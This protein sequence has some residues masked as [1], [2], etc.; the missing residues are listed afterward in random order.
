MLAQ[1][2]VVEMRPTC[3]TIAIIGDNGKF[4][5]PATGGLQFYALTP[6]RVADTRTSQP[7]TGAFGPPSLTVYT[8]RNFPIQS[9]PVESRQPHRRMR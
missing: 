6:C 8:D 3:L 7:F 9:S 4:A 1:N 5:A 2:G